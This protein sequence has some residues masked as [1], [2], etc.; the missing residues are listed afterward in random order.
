[1]EGSED[2][3][4]EGRDLLYR[5]GTQV[6]IVV[7][8]TLVTRERFSS[9]SV[10]VLVQN[11]IVAYINS[12]GLGDPVQLSDIQGE[13]RSKISGVDNLIITRMSRSTATGAADITLLPSEYPTTSPILVTISG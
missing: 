10:R 1:L 7:E 2:V 12:L 13:V 11:V 5:Q 9:A 4:V 6:S 3:A 8:C